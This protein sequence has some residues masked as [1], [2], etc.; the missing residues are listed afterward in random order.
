MERTDGLGGIFLRIHVASPL[1]YRRVAQKLRERHWPERQIGAEPRQI[2]RF[3]WLYLA[4]KPAS[5][6]DIAG[7]V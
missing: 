3:S 6:V 5:Q 7:F 2:R 4:Q 1:I